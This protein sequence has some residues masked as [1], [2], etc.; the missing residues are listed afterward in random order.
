MNRD[1]EIADRIVGATFRLVGRWFWP[2]VGLFLAI[3]FGIFAL[4]FTGYFL[5]GAWNW[6]AQFHHAMFLLVVFSF[7]IFFALL[8]A[9]NIWHA[10]KWWKA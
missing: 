4:V 3:K 10:I 1:D 2:L 8:V 9:A 5:A 6:T 7:L